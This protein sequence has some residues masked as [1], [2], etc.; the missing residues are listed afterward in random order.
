MLE[1]KDVCARCFP[2]KRS[3]G[4]VPN[5]RNRFGALLGRQTCCEGPGQARTFA[6]A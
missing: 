4:L 6:M 2:Q 1:T 5:E 3:L